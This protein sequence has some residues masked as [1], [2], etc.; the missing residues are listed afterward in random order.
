MPSL[1]PIFYFPVSHVS[2]T[3]F[4]RCFIWGRGVTLS[5]SKH[6]LFYR[7][8]KPSPSFTIS[9]ALRVF[10]KSQQPSSMYSSGETC[11]FPYT[12]F[13]QTLLFQQLS[14][15]LIHWGQCH[16][17]CRVSFFHILKEIEHS[18]N[19]EMKQH[20]VVS[21]VKRVTIKKSGRRITQWKQG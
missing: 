7:N 16:F 10:F 4:A 8:C 20:H 15:L 3:D 5:C 11:L 9:R 1:S 18:F 13:I 21:H 2:F 6:K 17:G 12:G 19:T 14:Q